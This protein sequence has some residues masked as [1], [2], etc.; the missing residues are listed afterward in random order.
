MSCLSF[1]VL[2]ERTNKDFSYIERRV[3]TLTSEILDRNLAELRCEVEFL[4]AQIEADIE[5]LTPSQ[6]ERASEKL[7]FF[8]E[9]AEIVRLELEDRNRP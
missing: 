6:L 5:N 4:Q 7:S 2:S 8:R 9:K 3:R 1:L